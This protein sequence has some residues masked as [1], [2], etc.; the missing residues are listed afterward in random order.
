MHIDN[1][2]KVIA[3]YLP[4]YHPTLDNN[5][6]WGK[7]F[8]E[9]T[10]VAKAKPLF[11]GH[12]Q[13]HIPADLGFYDLRLSEVRQA[14]A[15]LA[16]EAGI[17]GFCYYHYWFGNEKQ[18]LE[19]PF[20]EVVKLGKPDFP[21]CLCWANESWYSKFWNKDAKVK[22]KKL[23]VEQTYPDKDDNAKH[24]YSLLSAFRD[25][26]Y[27][28]IDDRPIFMIYKPLDFPKVDS[29]I[30]E[31]KTLALK[32]GL[33]GIYFIGYTLRI[34][35]EYKKIINAG[36][37]AVN[38]CR[39]D[40]I[41]I[42]KNFFLNFIKSAIR[43]SENLIFHRPMRIRYAKAMLQFVGKEEKINNI[44]PTLIPN[45]DHTPR[46]GYNGYLYT[47]STP[48][49]FEKHALQVFNMI[50]S[51]PEDDR[52]CFLK[53]WNEWG[54]GNYMEPDLKFGKKYIYALRSALQRGSDK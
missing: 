7:G 24:F 48:E 18:E 45:W 5:L 47:K 38:S 8:T 44:F 26:R 25:S 51:K 10:N 40:Q 17:E 3:F 22:S 52:I 4:Q 50:N 14:Q 20:N 46:S 12:Y 33:K 31:W 32:N 43:K 2:I 21:F 11:S 23:L 42:D 6:W 1:K 35:T 16:Q 36:F 30:Q 37:D 53:S 34:E 49:L 9:W 19:M 27:I 28:K 54:E 29:F 15:E 39:L 41:T 13:P